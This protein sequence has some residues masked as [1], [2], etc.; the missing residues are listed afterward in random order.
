MKAACGLRATPNPIAT[1]HI[2][3]SR[4]RV[5]TPKGCSCSQDPQHLWT[6]EV[7]DSTRPCLYICLHEFM[8]K[9]KYRQISEEFYL[10]TWDNGEWKI[11]HSD[12]ILEDY[13]PIN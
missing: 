12:K 13:L 8:D 7:S 5:S 3:G 4:L 2:S 11:L 6:R 9:A 1:L 10:V